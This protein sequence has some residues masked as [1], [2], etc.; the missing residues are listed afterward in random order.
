METKYKEANVEKYKFLQNCKVRYRVIKRTDLIKHQRS[1]ESV[2][3]ETKFYG[4]YRSRTEY[5]PDG[6]IL[7]TEYSKYWGEKIVEFWRFGN[8]NLKSRKIPL[9]NKKELKRIKEKIKE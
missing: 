4:G 7:Y 5:L 8:K 1:Y 2:K 6:D 3:S 9:S